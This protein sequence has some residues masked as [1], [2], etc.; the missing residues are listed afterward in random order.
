MAIYFSSENIS[1]EL[2]SKL[3]VK[4]WISE[5]IKQQGRRV[6]DI[7]YV[8]CDDAHLIEIN[9]A[10]LNH[11]TYTD[12]IT[13]DYV[14]GKV[15][16]GDIMISIERIKENAHLFNASFDRELHRVLI[17]GILHLLGQQDKTEDDASMMRKK[18]DEALL[19]WDS[20]Q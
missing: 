18:E 1:F 16:S 8:F 11:D 12:I 10:Y 4:K 13:F 2:K 5:I 14:E 3:L 19:L 20:M 15:I 6:G 17:H 7:S 9:R